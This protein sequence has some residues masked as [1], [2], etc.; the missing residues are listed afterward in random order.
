MTQQMENV[1][2]KP[3]MML[4]VAMI[5]IGIAQHKPTTMPITADDTN[6]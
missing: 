4:C 6:F 1:A 3:V 5:R 2:S